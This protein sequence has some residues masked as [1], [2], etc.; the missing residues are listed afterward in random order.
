V[1]TSLSDSS[2]SLTQDTGRALRITE[3]FYSLQ[4]EARTVGLPTVFV[5]LTGCPLRCVYCDTEY[6]FTGGEI[7]NV[8]EIAQRVAAYAPRYVTVTGGEPLAQPNCCRC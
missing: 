5:R 4:G 8:E 3:I 7:H 1:T 6:A 2:V